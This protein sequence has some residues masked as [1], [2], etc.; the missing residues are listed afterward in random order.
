MRVAFVVV[1]LVGMSQA[2]HAD[3]VEAKKAAQAEA[4]RKAFEQCMSTDNNCEYGTSQNCRP[5]VPYGD[6][7]GSRFSFSRAL[8]IATSCPPAEGAYDDVF[9]KKCRPQILAQ[10]P[11]DMV[12]REKK[13]YHELDRRNRALPADLQCQWGSNSNGEH[14]TRFW[15]SNARNG[16]ATGLQE[17]IATMEDAN[18][19]EEC[20]YNAEFAAGRRKLHEDREAQCKK[21]QTEQ[22]QKDDQELQRFSSQQQADA[23]KKKQADEQNAKRQ[24]AA[25]KQRADAEARA[26]EEE[27]RREEK[28]RMLAERYQEQRAA[29]D[30][31]NT[32]YAN[33]L[34][35]AMGA[36]HGGGNHPKGT[37]RYTHLEIGMGFEVMPIYTNTSGSDVMS[38]SSGSSAVGLGPQF[39]LA[40]APYHSARFMLGGYGIGRIQG[41][42]TAGG[43]MAV[44]GGEFGLKGA[45]GPERSWQLAYKV[46]YGLRYGSSNGNVGAGIIDAYSYGDGSSSYSRIG[47][48]FRHCGDVDDEDDRFCQRA[49]EF[50]I[51]RDG[52]GDGAATTLSL[53]FS[54]FRVITLTGELGIGVPRPG[55]PT[56]DTDDSPHGTS[57]LF[58]FAHTWDFFGKP[59]KGTTRRDYALAKLEESTTQRYRDLPR[60]QVGTELAFNGDCAPASGGVAYGVDKGRTGLAYSFDGEHDYMTLPTPIR[61]RA[62]TLAAWLAVKQDGTAIAGGPPGRGFTIGSSGSKL[63]ANIEGVGQLLGPAINADDWHHVALTVTPTQS[64]LIVDGNVVAR[65]A[66]VPR[67]DVDRLV[68][69]G[70]REGTDAHEVG[71]GFIGKIDELHVWS[72]PAGVVQLGAHAFGLAPPTEDAT[73]FEGTWAHPGHPLTIQIRRVAD[74]VWMAQSDGMVGVGRV[75]GGVLKLAYTNAQ[76]DG[77]GTMTMG[78]ETTPESLVETWSWQG[79][80]PQPTWAFSRTSP[81]TDNATFAD[82]SKFFVPPGTKRPWQGAQ[83]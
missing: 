32:Q 73:K 8:D 68:L 78:P 59:R 24:E 11:K 17:A 48:G 42:A 37:S 15:C 3:E 31:A 63:V 26:A 2:A 77:F 71:H 74:E 67:I 39:Q 21:A 44:I 69:G 25:D 34:G 50:M 70:S 6:Q 1:A 18:R 38:Y 82:P 45:Y 36:M 23:D 43:T 7:W 76:H 9:S 55:S 51:S 10:I 5:S 56:Y 41:M 58:G 28:A 20:V 65:A 14:I 80:A 61:S 40:I 53:R 33:D 27:R 16:C 62:F 30:A 35:A 64:L 57:F 54:F 52:Y 66:G 81:T 4:R 83:K 12:D 72:R 60:C 79:S 75:E 46:G 19:V 47:I 22:E 49:T 29:A 13:H